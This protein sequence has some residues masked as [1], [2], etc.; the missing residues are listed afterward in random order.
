MQTEFFFVL[1]ISSV[2]QYLL[3]GWLDFRKGNRFAYPEVLAE[4]LDEPV[5]VDI[6][7]LAAFSP[8]LDRSILQ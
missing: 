5:V 4:F 7:S 3:D 6:H 1:I 2:Q 8:R